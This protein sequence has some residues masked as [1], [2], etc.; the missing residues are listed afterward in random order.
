MA[1][2]H[3]ACQQLRLTWNPGFL[4]PGSEILSM[5][6]SVRL[7]IKPAD[8]LRVSF[9]RVQVLSDLPISLALLALVF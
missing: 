6:H 3:T 5:S 8:Y 9:S 1:H 7:G 4:D 2:G